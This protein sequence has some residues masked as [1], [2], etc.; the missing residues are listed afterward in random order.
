MKSYI[1]KSAGVLIAAGLLIVLQSCSDAGGT[2]KPAE[3]TQ[4]VVYVQTRELKYQPFV[5]YI[6]IIGI[7]KAE[8][9]AEL[10]ADGGGIIKEY[11]KD[12]GQF[13]KEGDIILIMDNDVLKANLDVAQ[14]QYDLAEINFRKQEQIY[15]EK[16][17]S[18][19]QYLNAMYERDA[20]KANY[21]L[22]KARYEKTFIR[23]PFS[24]VVDKKYYEEGETAPPGVPVVSF[25]K[26]DKI[27]IEAGVPEN[28]VNSIKKGDPVKVVFNDLDGAEY[29]E[30]VSY[31]GNT[32]SVNNRT[33]PIEILINNKDRKIKPELNARVFVEKA[34]IEK[35][36]VIPEEVLTRTDHGYVVFVEENGFSRMRIVD[37]ISRYDNK[38]AI[39]NGLT[40]G[41]KLIHVG[42]Q[43]LVDGEK[44][45]T[46]N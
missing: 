36:I 27:K 38:A 7:A 31:V 23:A 24:G 42:Y 41:E 10:A 13:V 30:S 32:L 19:L 46:V 29:F 17:T 44:V 6:S 26:I 40:E 37:V 22:I 15:K 9:R 43:N 20:A 39:R 45:R 1:K 34:N 21:E 33:F 14:A 5:D 3:E 16:V 35:A 11:L 12:K 25:V 8:K 4:R 2:E 28:Y 18:E